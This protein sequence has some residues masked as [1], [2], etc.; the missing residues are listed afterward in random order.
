MAGLAAACELQKLH[1]PYRLVEARARLGGRVFTGLQMEAM[2]IEYGA[3]FIHGRP[4][5][6]WQI[7]NQCQ[8]PVYETAGNHWR[9]VDGVI[10]DT[11]K[12]RDAVDKI[13]ADVGAATK[14]NDVSFAGYLNSFCSEQPA[15]AKNIARS[16]VEGF[17]AAD[18]D[19]ISSHSLSVENVAANSWDDDASFRLLRGYQPIVDYFARQLNPQNI[20][21]K[22]PVRQIDWSHAECV[23]V[24]CTDGSNQSGAS[25]TFSAKQAIITLPISILQRSVELDG[26]GDELYTPDQSVIF[27]PALGP[28]IQE[29]IDSFV[30]GDAARVTLQFSRRF[31][32]E[33]FLNRSDGTTQSLWNMGFVHCPE[34][35]IPT[36]WTM[37]PLHLPIVV[38]WVAGP[39][40]QRLQS[41]QREDVVAAAIHSFSCI[42]REDEAVVREYL[43]E[44]FYHDWCNDPFSLG[45][46][47]YIKVNGLEKARALT[48]PV[49]NKLIFAGEHTDIEGYWSTVHGAIRSGRRAAAQILRGLV[50]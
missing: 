44:A 50:Q 4:E 16:F 42:T 25:T 38:G 19:V 31:W 41:R 13:L 18:A 30:M 2:A 28:Q 11:S 10:A 15:E 12:Y 8:F 22:C 32:E 29:A 43:I 26:R 24:H 48:Q 23:Q 9:V 35:T 34:A 6:L 3:E 47:S 45:A 14:G 20:R 7:I 39:Y 49:A 46:Y 1:I 37:L 21:L 5:E 17:N 40:T 36:W 33:R 27:T